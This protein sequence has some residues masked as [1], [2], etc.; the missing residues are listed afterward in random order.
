M[1]GLPCYE[2]V[3]QDGRLQKAANNLIA[4]SQIATDLLAAKGYYDSPIL[5]KYI[6]FEAQCI[7]TIKEM[8]TNLV[9]LNTQFAQENN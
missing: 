2:K 9:N 7:S 5:Q 1:G 6:E 8:E 4:E 3:L